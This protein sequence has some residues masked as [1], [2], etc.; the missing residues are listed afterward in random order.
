MHNN[1]YLPLTGT[2]LNIF[3]ISG[4]NIFMKFYNTRHGGAAI[5]FETFVTHF[6]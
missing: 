6:H 2:Y 1:R 5:R 3:D 4:H